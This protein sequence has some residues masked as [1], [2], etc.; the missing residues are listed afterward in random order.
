MHP[1]IRT[2]L[3]P[4]ILI[5]AQQGWAKP[6]VTHSEKSLA[7]ICINHD[8]SNE[9]LIEIC[10]KAL[11]DPAGASARQ[12]EL[13]R[14]A[15]GDAYTRTG[16]YVRAEEQYAL[17]LRDNPNSTAGLVGMG[18]LFVWDDPERAIEFLERAATL[19]TS[20]PIVAGLARARFAANL[21]TSEEL[22]QQL[23]IALA[24][25]PEYSWALREKGW[26]LI[27]LHREA[28]AEAPLQA[29]LD[30]NPN[31]LSALRGMA[32]AMIYLKP[33]RALDSIN[34]AIGLKPDDIWPI[35]QR[36][37]ALYQLQRYRQSIKD[38]ERLIALDPTG[39]EGYVQK[40]KNLAKLG[41]HRA[42]LELLE[43]SAGIDNLKDPSYLRYWHASLLVDNGQLQPAHDL[44]KINLNIKNIDLHNHR[45]M[46][47]ILL[48]Q[49]TPEQALPYLDQALEMAPDWAR[50]HFLKARGM[51]LLKRPEEAFMAFEVAKQIGHESWM[52]GDVASDLVSRGLFVE[53][54][55]FRT[56]FGE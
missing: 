28:E 41:E 40:A 27:Y 43:A 31:D 35:A 23:D 51:A 6:L 44:L 20:A 56:T 29:A 21:I 26:R 10:T 50:L 11:H 54:I 1:T 49:G 2:L 39:S 8:D 46:A 55:R 7:Q 45:L 30:L 36:S 12:V 38:A 53:A 52:V 25:D 32:R 19:E 5:A 9:R 18:W 37:E 3:I 15:L 14:R 34:R 13:M 4:G 47:Y 33:A 22:I 48:E 16:Q 24:I 17:I 42:A